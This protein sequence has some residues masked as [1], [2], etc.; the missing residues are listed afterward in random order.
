VRVYGQD[1]DVV[2]R[3]AQKVRDLVADID[4]VVDPQVENQTDQPTLRVEVDLDKARRYGIKPG[5]V[6]RAEASLLQGIQVGSI[7]QDQKVFS[8]IV[9][10]VPEI[11]RNV[12][13][14]RN[15]LIDRPDGGTVRLGDVA[16]VTVEPTPAVIQRDAV[17]RRVDVE[18]GVDGAQP[19]RREGRHREP[20]AGPCGSRSSTTPRSSRRRPSKEIG[21]AT[22]IGFASPPSSRRSAA[23]RPR[24]Q[25]GPWRAGRAGQ[26]AGRDRGRR[27]WW[28]SVDGA[29]LTLGRHRRLPVRSFGL[30]ARNAVLMVGGLQARPAR[31]GRA[32][33]ARRQR[34]ARARFHRSVGRHG[35][36]AGLPGGAVRG[37]G[38]AGRPGDPAPDGPGRAR[39][40][41]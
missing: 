22:M 36:R 40:A 17:S 1:L 15:L 12:Q 38:L 34:G 7:F 28:R 14:V 16:D 2:K 33:R 8:V 20:P 35:G 29:D 13:D 21:S 27:V 5:D 6:R 24:S 31:R 41:W 19:G 4:G 11:R 26:P 9:Q 18:A 30:A 3:E 23:R 32:D 37:D 25:L 10:G 39:A